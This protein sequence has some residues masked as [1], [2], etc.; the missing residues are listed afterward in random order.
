MEA[1]LSTPFTALSGSQHQAP[2]FTGDIYYGE[3]YVEEAII[4]RSSYNPYF[5][6]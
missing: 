2:S 5:K 1:A 3:S 6:C 4:V